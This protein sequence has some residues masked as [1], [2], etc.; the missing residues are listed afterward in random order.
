[1]LTVR[2]INATIRED[3]GTNVYAVIAGEKCR[4]MRARTREGAMQVRI[5]ATGE[6]VSS[7]AV[8]AIVTE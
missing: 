5:L 3:R 6:W 2:E 1:M 4:V 7:L 8:D